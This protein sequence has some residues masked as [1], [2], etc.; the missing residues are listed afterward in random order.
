[1]PFHEELVR[2]AIVAQGKLE[3]EIGRKRF[4]IEPLYYFDDAGNRR[5]LLRTLT[6]R[7]C[8]ASRPG[9]HRAVFKAGLAGVTRWLNEQEYWARRGGPPPAPAAPGEARGR[10]RPRRPRP[11]SSR[12][13]GR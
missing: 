11:W 1:M 4:R 6:V 2:R 12:A 10:G 9:H 7:E 5:P 3:V 13:P 8:L